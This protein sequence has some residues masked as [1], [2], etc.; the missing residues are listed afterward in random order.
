[1]RGGER[2]VSRGGTKLE[3]ALDSLVLDVKGLECADIGASTGGFTDCL[4]Q[5]GASKVHAVDVGHGLLAASLRNDPRVRVLERT[6]ARHL[7]A[8][9][10]GREVE[11]VVVDASFISIGKLLPAIDAILKPG[12]Q[13]LALVKPQFEAGREEAARGRG[14]IRDPEV[15]ARTI[16]DAEQA[17]REQGFAILGGADSSAR[18]QG[19]RRVLRAREKT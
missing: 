8:G 7:T 1:M 3:G 14:V 18:P 9:G 10:S 13:L 19:Q 4:L 16:R 17:I 5:R 2:Y 15:R 11:L 12:G 6:N